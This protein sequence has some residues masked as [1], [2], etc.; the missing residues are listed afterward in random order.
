MLKKLALL[1]FVAST[2]MLAMINLPGTAQSC[3]CGQPGCGGECANRGQPL[4]VFSARSM[5]SR[6]GAVGEGRGLTPQDAIMD[7]IDSCVASG[8]IPACCRQGA[9][10]WQE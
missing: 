9:R 4:R 7:A 5:C 3:P 6:T 1:L 10:V 2:S 8:G